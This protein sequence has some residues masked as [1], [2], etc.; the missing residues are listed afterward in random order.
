MKSSN[1]SSDY[2]ITLPGVGDFRF[3]QETYADRIAIRAHYLGLVKDFKDTDTYL[4]T[5]AGLIAEFQQLCVS[6]PP[7]WQDLASQ[8]ITDQRET[9]LFELVKQLR[10]QQQSFRN[11]A[12]QGGQAQG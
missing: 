9:Q 11:S 10:Q 8:V 2:F 3:S 5:Y 1:D 4:S 7:D 6:C 12:A